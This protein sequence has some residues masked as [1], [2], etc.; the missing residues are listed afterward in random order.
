[1]G[2][3]AIATCPC[4]YDSGELLIGPGM[5]GPD[6]CYFPAFCKEGGHLVDVNMCDQPRRCPEGHDK[7]PVPYNATSLIKELGPAVVADY[8]WLD[9]ANHFVLTDG[10]YLCPACHQYTLTFGEGGTMWD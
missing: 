5:S 7:E 8:G 6:P 10:S 3:T 2:C 4:G 9:P 1:M